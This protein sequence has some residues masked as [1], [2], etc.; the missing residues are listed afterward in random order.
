MNFSNISAA[1]FAELKEKE[2]HVVIDVRSPQELSEGSIPGHMMINI[3]D[4]EFRV[5]IS[6]LDRDMTYLVY[7]RS[8]GRSGQ[9]CAIMNQLGFLSV[10]N[11]AGG[12]GAW[13][14]LESVK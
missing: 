10:Y 3:F 8:G 2:N 14:A 13:N 12:I 6:K 7:C 9:A 4:P 11:L 5:K 1:Q